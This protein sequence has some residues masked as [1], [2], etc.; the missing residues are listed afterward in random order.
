MVYVGHEEGF[1]SIWEIDTEDGYR[2]ADVMKVSATDILSLEGVHNRLWAGDRNETIS[3]YDVSQKPWVVTNSWNAHPGFPVMKLMINHY[4]ITKVGRL[5]V[6]SIG[7]DDQLRLWDGLLGW[8][9]V[10]E[11]SVPPLKTVVLNFLST[12]YL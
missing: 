12:V 4:A 5:C 10:G 1:I 8:D 6:A 7:G 3:A 9:W 2:C 11:F